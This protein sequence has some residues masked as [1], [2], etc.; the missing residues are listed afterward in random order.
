MTM[1]FSASGV[2]CDSWS[3]VLARPEPNQLQKR[4]RNIIGLKLPYSLY[5]RIYRIRALN[6]VSIPK[7]YFALNLENSTLFQFLD[8]FREGICSWLALGAVIGT[9]RRCRK[10]AIALSLYL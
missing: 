9:S 2:S 6:S 5:K 10:V 7:Q 4:S 1:T 3:I 8:P